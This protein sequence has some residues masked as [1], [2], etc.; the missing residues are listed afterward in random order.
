MSYVL[1]K[2]TTAKLILLHI[3]DAADGSLGKT[4]LAPTT[5]GAS[6][7]YLREGEGEP[8]RIPLVLARV[9]EYIPG[10]MAEADAQ[11]MPGIYQFG[12]PNAVLEGGADS[13]VVYLRFPGAIVEPIQIS[14]VAYDP[15]DEAQMGMSALAPKAG[16][17]RSAALFREW[18]PGS[19]TKCRR[20][21]KLPRRREALSPKAD[22]AAA[23][24]IA[25]HR[26]Q[27]GPGDNRSPR[28]PPRETDSRAQAR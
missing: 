18:L 14:L 6:A 21:S 22:R 23:A 27:P 7:A 9:G 5:P 8:R 4:G 17:Q 13:V 2:G 24:A 16:S 15:Q 10:G 3:R 25:V 26:H 11:L 12:L 1:K 20:S 19:S 28:C